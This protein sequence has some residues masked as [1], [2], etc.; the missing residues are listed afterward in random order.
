MKNILIIGG[1]RNMGY[2]LTLRLIAANHRVT[3]LNRGMSRVE[4]PESVHRLHA[5][6]SDPQQMQRALLAKKFDV[7]VDFVL[8]NKTDAEAIV[9]VMADKADHYIMISSGQ[10]YLVREGAERP[11]SEADYDGRLQP[12]PKPNT[13][14]YEEWRYGMGK[15]EAE[16]VLFNAHAESGFPATTLRLPMVNSERDGFNR[17]YAYVLRLR[18]GGPILVPET[19]SYPLRHVYGK[20]VV[21]AIEKLIALET[22]IGKSYNIS[23]DE[24]VSLDEFL[25]LLG[26][27][28]GVTPHPV[29]IKRSRL[30]ADGFVPD[31]SPF[32]ERWMSELTNDL[33]K[34][35]LGMNYTPLR[36]YLSKLVAVYDEAKPPAPTSY[37]RR[38]AEL[39][40]AEE[41]MSQS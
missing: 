16:D 18:D 31:C 12:A 5:D 2:D 36:E 23:Q 19:P 34:A 8:F 6:R 32:S 28:M 10:V 37:K 26:D 38:P 11:Y 35:E 39:R 24:T 9:K 29:R 33:S 13:F 41:V 22:G 20:D 3:V 21:S 27:I 1:T 14:A 40:L 7:V 30:E 15:R 25:D 17:L 4:L